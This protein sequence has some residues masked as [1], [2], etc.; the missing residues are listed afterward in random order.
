MGVREGADELLHAIT[1]ERSSKNTIFIRYGFYLM[2]I[3]IICLLENEKRKEK[4]RKDGLKFW[5]EVVVVAV[6]VMYSL[7]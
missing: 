6:D 5:A 3:F 1:K 2:A 7:G 4:K